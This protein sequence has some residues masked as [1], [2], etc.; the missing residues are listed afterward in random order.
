KADTSNTLAGNPPADVGADTGFTNVLYSIPRPDRH[1]SSIPQLQHF[2][3]S[4]FING[5]RFDSS[6]AERFSTQANTFQ[7]NYP[8]R[9]S[10]P[11]PRVPRERAYFASTGTS[12]RINIGVAYDASWLYNEVF[13]DRFFFS[14]YPASGNFDF[15][16]QRLTNQNIRPFRKP[17]VVAWDDT[18]G[19]RG[20]PR[21]AASNLMINGAFNINSTSVE[22]WKAVLSSIRGVPVSGDNTINTPFARGLYQTR[23][24]I[25][26][27]TG[28]TP[29]A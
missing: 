10:Y 4:G 27:R 25:G 24:Y 3:P 23:N 16:D 15:T 11:T 19:F 22:A 9:T 2:S 1:P 29:G 6:T 18:T 5:G 13:A 20:A 17:S 21:T 12:G 28:N 7:V 26:A 14:T 8:I